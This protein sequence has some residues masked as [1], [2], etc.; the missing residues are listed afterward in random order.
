MAIP[1]NLICNLTFN[2]PELV[3]LGPIKDT[4]IQKLEQILPQVCTSSPGQKTVVQFQKNESPPHWFAKLG[5]MFCN[6]EMGQSQIMLKLMDC[7][8]DEGGWKLKGSNAINHDE[9]KVTYKFFFVQ[10]L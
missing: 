6:E 9:T 4:T 2:P 8:E 7:L 3:I 1:A 10:K 5:T